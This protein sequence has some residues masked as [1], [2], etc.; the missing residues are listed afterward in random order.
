M[1]AG[2]INKHWFRRFVALL[3]SRFRT[4]P[5][6]RPAASSSSSHPGEPTHALDL[7]DLAVAQFVHDLRNQLT[8]AMACTDS[9]AS[10]LPF[11]CGDLEI[12]ALRH[13]MQRSSALTRDLLMAAQPRLVNRVALDLNELIAAAMVTITRFMG[14]HIRLRLRLATDPVLISAEALE[15]E[16]ILMNLVL[17]A[18]H[19]MPEVTPAGREAVLTIETAIVEKGPTGA[20][21][22][23]VPHAR[24]TVIDTGYGMTA[25]I[26]E[27]IFE[28]FYTTR[29]DGTGLGLSSVAFTVRQLRGSVEVKSDLGKGTHI[30]VYVPAV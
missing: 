5:L 12:A 24:L 16:R 29:S 10:L 17:N 28:P 26:Q 15:V 21:T 22:P 2:P 19:A 4:S 20:Q 18:C 1:T 6:S 27:R 23:D 30:S 11:G 9:I 13:C 14:G 7:G 25:R 8:V 3:A